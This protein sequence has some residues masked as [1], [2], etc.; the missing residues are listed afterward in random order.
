MIH[1]EIR[2]ATQRK[3]WETVQKLEN[4]LKTKDERR[5]IQAET[6]LLEFNKKLAEISVIKAKVDVDKV[7]FDRKF[8]IFNFFFGSGVLVVIWNLIKD[9]PIIKQFFNK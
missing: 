2:R 5:K 7:L 4:I 9:L 6:E 8:S 1:K 3:D